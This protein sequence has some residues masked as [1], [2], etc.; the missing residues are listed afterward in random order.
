MHANA[1]GFAVSSWHK[2]VTG[3]FYFRNTEQK[4]LNPSAGLISA[5]LCMKEQE[6]QCQ[7]SAQWP[8]EGHWFECLWPNNQRHLA[9]HPPVCQSMSGASTVELDLHLPWNTRIITST[10]GIQWFTRSTRD[11]RESVWRSCREHYA[12]CNINRYGR[13]DSGF[14]DGLGRD[15]HEAMH[16][17]LQAK[18]QHP[19][20]Y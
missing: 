11:R 4:I 19:D 7:N 15:I 16:R 2:S 5:L 8:P 3:D 17:P 14:S 13:F 1:R 6:E 9:Q 10:T 12:V 20:C 18:Q